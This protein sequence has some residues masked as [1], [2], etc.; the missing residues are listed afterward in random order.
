MANETTTYLKYANVQMAAEALFNLQTASPGSIFSGSLA[1]SNLNILT[2]GNNRSSKFTAMQADEFS[3]DWEVVEHKSNTSTGFSGTLF[4]AF[5]TDQARG[6][7]SGELVLS[8][9]STELIDDSARDNQATNTMEVKPYGWAFGQIDDMEKWYAELNAAASKL[10]GKNF[11]VAGYSLGGHLTTAFGLLRQDQGQSNRVTGTYTFN[12]AGVGEMASG[13]LTDAIT[14]FDNARNNGSADLF[15]SSVAKQLYASLRVSIN[16]QAS[17]ADMGQALANIAQAQSIAATNNNAQL[18]KELGLL[19]DAVKR[20]KAVLDEA[21]FGGAGAA[22]IYGDRSGL[23][24]ISTTPG[25][26]DMKGDNYVDSGASD[27]ATYLIATNDQGERA[28]SLFSSETVS[29]IDFGGCKPNVA[30]HRCSKHQP[31]PSAR[32]SALN[33]LGCRIKLQQPRRGRF[34]QCSRSKHLNI[35]QNTS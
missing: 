33:R 17:S 16:G 29:E 31:R 18:L 23:Q 22:H 7:T 10:Q 14:L 3:R 24:A 12:G 34:K 2:V 28:I 25:A 20:T 6:I 8:F 4:R 5:R 32:G 21:I 30:A 1:G 13:T 35:K 9:R 27:Y 15:T 11:A 19:N 26:Q